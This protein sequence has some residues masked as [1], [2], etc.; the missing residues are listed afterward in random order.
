M[1]ERYYSEARSDLR[2]LVDPH[3]A[4]VLDVGCG[5]GALGAVLKADG[6]AYV[7][8]IEMHGPAAQI[9]RKRLDQLVEGSVVDGCLPFEAASFNYL[10]FGDVLE[11][12]ADPDAAL[13]RCLPFLMP[14]GRV[15]ISVPNWRFYS[16][17]LRLVF[18]RWQYTEAG[19]RDRT[20]LRV[21]TRYSLE[22]FIRR[23][24]LDLLEF[25]RNHRLIED[26]SHIGR[27]GALATRLSNATLARWI[28]PELLSFQYVALASKPV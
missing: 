10:I 15:I 21:F 6:A 13:K 19:V 12:L 1:S 2:S 18:D 3:N 14:G 27:A 26:Q 22:Q 16:V 28:F 7:A 24:G 9:A 8:G 20:H 11:H 25:H 4:R 17:L 5:T 23:N